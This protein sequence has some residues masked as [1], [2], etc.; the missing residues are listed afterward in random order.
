M[1][2]YPP[3]YESL[4]WDYK[5][6]NNDAIINS[7]NQANWEFLFFN[8]NVHQQVYIFSKTLM[9]TFSNFIPNRYVT[10]NNKYPPWM[11]NYLKPKI[12]C[13]NNLCL[14]YLKHGKRN[15]DYIELQRSIEEVS[16]DISKSKEQYYDC[17]AKKL[18]NPKTSP[19]TYWATMKIF[20]N[21]KKTPLIPPLL[22]NDKLECDFGKKANHFNEFFASKCTPLNNGSTLPHS[23]SNAPTVELS[24]FQFNDQDI[25]KI[26]RALHVNKAHGCDDIP[27]RMIKICDQSIVKFLSII[28]QN[29]LNARNFPDI[30]KNSNIVVNN[31][32]PVSLLP[33]CG[34]ILERLV[35]NSI[36]DF[37]DNNSLL[38]ANQS[39]FR[40]SDSCESQLLSICHE[41]Y[42][43]F[44]CYP[45]LEVRGYIF[46]I[47]LK[48]LTESGM[49]GCFLKLN[50]WVYLFLY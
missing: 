40:P 30:W 16:E 17:L 23:V 1:I 13:K 41:I 2:V 18:N 7:I 34:K 44:D 36:F 47:Y 38:S 26:I 45:T 8:D 19:K 5:R 22:V 10:F 39:D 33:V 31:Y 4:V 49:K 14:K 42:A 29:C 32:R 37:L 43:S 25:L 11:T 48:Y 27:I 12:H 21:G 9:N 28:Y 6:A 35:F 15:C 46:W 50:Q 24:S 3:P 20:Y